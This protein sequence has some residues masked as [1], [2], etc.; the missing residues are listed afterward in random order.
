MAGK[1]MRGAGCKSLVVLM[2]SGVL[3]RGRLLRW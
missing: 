1:D 2:R 3:I